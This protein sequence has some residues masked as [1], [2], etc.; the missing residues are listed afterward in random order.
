MI[1]ENDL[2]NDA[3]LAEF[4][5][6]LVDGIAYYRELVKEL[7]EENT[8]ARNKFLHELE[9]CNKRLATI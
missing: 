5:Q 7:T 9:A 3:T 4:R 1:D 2:K 8:A 6:N